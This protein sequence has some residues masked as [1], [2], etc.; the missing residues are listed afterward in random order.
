MTAVRFLWLSGFY[1]RNFYYFYFKTL[2]FQFK[3]NGIMQ[4][5]NASK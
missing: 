5:E 1:I 2:T 4:T 3:H